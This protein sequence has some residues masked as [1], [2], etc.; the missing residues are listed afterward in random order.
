[1]LTLVVVPVG[2]ALLEGFKDRWKARRQAK[3]D[4]AAS[5]AQQLKSRITPTDPTPQG[6]I[7]K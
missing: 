6:V 4:R 5:V 2:Y 7:N 1:L 3:K